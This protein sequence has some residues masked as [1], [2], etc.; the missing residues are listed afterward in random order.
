MG[1]KEKNVL[2]ICF[3]FSLYFSLCGCGVYVA[4][5]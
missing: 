3:P 1:G 5:P 2:S 4:R